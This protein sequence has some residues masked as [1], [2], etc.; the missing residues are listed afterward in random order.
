MLLR[1]GG[2]ESLRATFTTT[3]YTWILNLACGRAARPPPTPTP[4]PYHCCL[5]FGQGGIVRVPKNDVTDSGGTLLPLRQFS[6]LSGN[7]SASPH[8][9]SRGAFHN[10]HAHV[11]VLPWLSNLME[12]HQSQVH[13]STGASVYGSVNS[14]VGTMHGAR[15]STA[16]DD[17][18]EVVPIDGGRTAGGAGASAPASASTGAISGSAGAIQSG[19]GPQCQI[20]TE[21]LIALLQRVMEEDFDVEQLDAHT[22]SQTLVCLGM[23]CCY[24]CV[25]M[26]TWAR[27]SLEVWR[28]SYSRGA[29]VTTLTFHRS[30][31]MRPASGLLTRW[32]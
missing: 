25:L 6:T 26:L 14:S 22:K 19:D 13:A 11:A 16:L 28:A 3:P 29:V 5:L 23:H 15:A 31:C 12:Y 18:C 21:P 4:T 9:D 2:M 10:D 27:G 7:V 17:D 32:S 24:K 20:R 8:H 1:V 30:V